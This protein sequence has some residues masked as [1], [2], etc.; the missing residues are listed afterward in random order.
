V[1][2]DRSAVFAD[3]RH[4]IESFASEHA[5]PGVAVGIIEHGELIWTH[6]AGELQRGGGS[7]PKPDSVFR[8]AS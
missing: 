4:R 7:V 1:N 2:T 3:T 6:G 5:L 8:I